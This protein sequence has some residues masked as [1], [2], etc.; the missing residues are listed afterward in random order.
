MKG[1]GCWL[2][3]KLKTGDVISVFE[4]PEGQIAKKSKDKEFLKF[5]CEFFVGA[6]KEVRKE[7]E[8]FKVQTELEKFNRYRDVSSKSR[9]GSMMA[10]ESAAPRAVQRLREKA[11]ERPRERLKEQRKEQ[12]K[13][14]EKE[15]EKEARPAPI[16]RAATPAPGTK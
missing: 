6:S 7:G 5:R 11:R 14:K 8:N 15:K 13:G 3:G 16:A 4:L 2:Y 10:S 12:P 9:E 1:E